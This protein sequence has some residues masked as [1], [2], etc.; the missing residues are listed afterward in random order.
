MLKKI[1][2]VQK[3]VGVKDLSEEKE[4]SGNTHSAIH[5]CIFSQLCQPRQRRRGCIKIFPRSY[6]FLKDIWGE[7]SSL[8]VLYSFLE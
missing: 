4:K 7:A 3:S 2:A 1:S 8:G 6:P 5:Q